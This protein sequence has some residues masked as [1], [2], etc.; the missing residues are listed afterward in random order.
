VELPKGAD[1]MGVLNLAS[2]QGVIGLAAAGIEAVQGEMLK[3]NGFPHSEAAKPSE[4]LIPKM[5]LL[6]WIGEVLVIEQRNKDMNA[7]VDDLIEKLRKRDV[8]TLLVKGQ[9]V[10]QCYE[11]PLWRTCGD[12]DLILSFDNYCKAK[13][14][15]T[16]IASHVDA[17]REDT[18]HLGMT[19]DG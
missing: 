15:L 2:E 9:G 11:K 14:Y 7:F 13:E 16:K 3:V 17:E 1:W 10:A 18:L 8:Y 6:Q 4:S 19:I 12:V 5:L